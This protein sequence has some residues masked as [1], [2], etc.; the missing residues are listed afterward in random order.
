MTLSEALPHLIAASV[1]GCSLLQVRLSHAPASVYFVVFLYRQPPTTSPQCLYH[2]TL[3]RRVTPPAH[4]RCERHRTH[5]VT[6][7]VHI[8]PFRRPPSPPLMFFSHPLETSLGRLPSQVTLVLHIAR[9]DETE[10]AGA[11]TAAA[12]MMTVGVA[13][14]RSRVPLA[15]AARRAPRLFFRTTVSVSVAAAEAAA[16]VVAAE[17]EEVDVTRSMPRAV[18]PWEEQEGTEEGPR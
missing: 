2:T 4:E 8:A 9:L 7:G 10:A 16:E 15:I 5:R 17:A 11:A 14:H 18:H 12:A 3:L 1:F 6:L 13:S